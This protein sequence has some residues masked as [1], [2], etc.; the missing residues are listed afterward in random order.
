MFELD[1]VIEH[2][3]TLDLKAQTDYQTVSIEDLDQI[4]WLIKQA[5]KAKYLEE[6]RDYWKQKYLL[7]QR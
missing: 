1:E 4:D 2:F 3:E 5:K 6:D 7:I